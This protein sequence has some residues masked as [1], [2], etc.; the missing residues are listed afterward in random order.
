MGMG[1]GLRMSM[2]Q[3]LILPALGLGA[4]LCEPLP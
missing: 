1:W 4:T 3:M 2:S